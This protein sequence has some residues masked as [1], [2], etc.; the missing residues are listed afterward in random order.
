AREVGEALDEIV[1]DLGIDID[2]LD[3]ATGL[4]R[5]VERP[6]DKILDGV[7]EL[8]VGPDI[9][10]VLAAELKSGRGEGAGGGTLD[11]AAA[12]DRAGEID[13]VDAAGPYQLLGLVMRHDEIVEQAL[14]QSCTAEGLG[15][16]LADQQRLRRVLQEDGVAGQ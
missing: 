12:G 8:G 2:A 13:V 16:S 11:G 7:I 1:I 10:R 9:G 6:V 4:P 3:P 14:R 5:I 15:K